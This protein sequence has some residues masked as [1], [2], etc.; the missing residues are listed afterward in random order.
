MSNLFVLRMSKSNTTNI[1][2]DIV[3]ILTEYYEQQ[4]AS[5]LPLMIEQG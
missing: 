1:T 4:A 3:N 5:R 2:K